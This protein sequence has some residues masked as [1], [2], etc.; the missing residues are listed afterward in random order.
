MRP[1]P[2][3]RLEVVCVNSG[4]PELRRCSAWAVGAAPW[5][6]EPRPAQAPFLRGH[7]RDV[8]A[9]RRRGGGKGRVRVCRVALACGWQEAAR[10][11][12]VLSCQTGCCRC[13]DSAGQGTAVVSPALR[14]PSRPAPLRGL[15]AFGCQAGSCGRPWAL[16]WAHPGDPS[17]RRAAARDTDKM[18]E[19]AASRGAP[20][21]LWLLPRG[22]RG[23][24]R[25]PQPG[26][27]GPGAPVGHG[28]GCRVPSGV[29]PP[30]VLLSRESGC[31]L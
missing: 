25:H 13:S 22:C 23:A 26:E 10:A 29:A 12:V 19:K 2:S 31:P 1:R 5:H 8:R 7:S 3:S 21:W 18:A 14:A 9:D 15:L 11:R 6:G 16:A 27:V 24:S 17:P 28:G 20:C 4:L 30:C